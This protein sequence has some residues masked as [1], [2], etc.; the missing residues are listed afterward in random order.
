MPNPYDAYGGG[1]SGGSWTGTFKGFF[2]TM[3][4]FIIIATIFI[5]GGIF[6]RGNGELGVNVPEAIGTTWDFAMH[7]LS[8][9][10][11]NQTPP[12]SETK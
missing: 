8:F 7:T 2:G 6:A 12:P 9:F 10:N 4:F 5:E 1:G 11:R 3:C